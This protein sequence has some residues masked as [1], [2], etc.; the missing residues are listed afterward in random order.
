M[1]E[2]TVARMLAANA[3]TGLSLLRLDGAARSG[4]EG[5][6]EGVFR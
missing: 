6:M 3:R 5:I 4:L 2:L 1:A